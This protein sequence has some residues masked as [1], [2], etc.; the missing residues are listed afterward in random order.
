MR[1]CKISNNT[2]KTT[3]QSLIRLKICQ[4]N[5]EQCCPFSF[6]SFLLLLTYNSCWTG[7]WV[8][9]LLML[10]WKTILGAFYLTTFLNNSHTMHEILLWRALGDTCAS[11]PSEQC[12][13]NKCSRA[14]ALHSRDALP[15]PPT[16]M[17]TAWC[18]SQQSREI[19]ER[20]SCFWVSQ[21][22]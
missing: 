12:I 13:I 9:L 3:L 16:C 14:M 4:E 15:S 21:V 20:M 2:V 17:H 8:R 5:T 11:H 6:L 7:C 10:D 19:T 22:T 18:P 1:N